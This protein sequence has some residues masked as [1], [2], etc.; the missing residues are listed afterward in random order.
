M[1]T[2]STAPFSTVIITVGYELSVYFTS[3]RQCMVELSVIIF[4]PPTGGAPR[5]LTLSVNTED[6]SAGT[7]MDVRFLLHQ[8]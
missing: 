3:E 2:N 7:T 6:G 5:P 1:N 4:D 8:K